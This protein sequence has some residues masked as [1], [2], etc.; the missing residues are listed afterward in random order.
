[1][2]FPNISNFIQEYITKREKSFFF[3]DIMN[4]HDKLMSQINGKSILSLGLRV[5]KF[6]PFW[7]CNNYIKF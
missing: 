4:N 2:I 5:Y 6:L 3:N 1:M 7:I